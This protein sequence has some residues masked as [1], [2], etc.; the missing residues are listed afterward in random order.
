M[1]QSEVDWIMQHAQAV[2]VD[3]QVYD[4]HPH[5]GEKGRLT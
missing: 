1:S 3:P 5:R 2:Q 4:V